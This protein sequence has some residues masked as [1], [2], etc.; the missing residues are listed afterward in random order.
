MG[1]ATSEVPL[2]KHRVEE[3]VIVC[4]ALRSRCSPEI[5]R[6]EWGACR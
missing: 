4:K 5:A 3:F 1:D 6:D 2:L